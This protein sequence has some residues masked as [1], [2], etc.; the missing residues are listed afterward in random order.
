MAGMHSPFDNYDGNE[1]N[2]GVGLAPL[3]H[4]DGVVGDGLI[5]QELDDQ[6]PLQVVKPKKKK[7]VL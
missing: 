2:Q 7:R 3:H 5:R 4:L 1:M 6:D